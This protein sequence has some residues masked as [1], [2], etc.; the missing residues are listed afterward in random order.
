MATELNAGTCPSPWGSA[1]CSARLKVL[2]EDFVVE[3]VL[4]FEPSGAGEHL[5]LW[6]EKRG[7]NTDQ[8]G[9]ELAAK[10]GLDRSVVSFSGLKDK[11]A[12]TRQWYSVQWPG[13]GV[14]SAGDDWI[15]LGGDGGR[16]RVLAQQRSARKLRRGAHESNQFVITLREVSGERDAIEARLQQVAKAGVANY[17]GAQRF[18]HGGRNIG[19]GLG[20]LADRRAGRKRRRDTRESIW[21]SSLRSALFNQVLSERVRLGCWDTYL[22]GDVLQLDGRGSFFQPDLTDAEWPA[23]LLSGDLH[24]TGP[25][26]GEGAAVVHDQVALLETEILAPWQSICDDLAAIR[27]PAQRRALRLRVADMRWQW[28]ETAENNTLELAFTLTAGSFATCVLEAFC[29]LTEAPRGE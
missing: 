11:N 7:L 3:E 23:R 9:Q 8:L 1:V 22:A 27:I 13:A 28:L 24:P 5:C 12:L 10:L 20:L 26:P 21:L 18:G 2:P 4:G 16:Y 14:W 29:L 15:E 17:F 6:V 25:L 19:Q